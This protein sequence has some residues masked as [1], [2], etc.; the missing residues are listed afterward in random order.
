MQA[1]RVRSQSTAK[2]AQIVGS[3]DVTFAFSAWRA[4]CNRVYIMSNKMS[5]L[6][7]FPASI[8]WMTFAS[9]ASAHPV[10]S[11]TAKPQVSR[12]SEE[13][14]CSGI[15]E[16]ER[17]TSLCLN[18]DEI[19]RV[20]RIPIDGRGGEVLTGARMTFRPVPGRTAES[21]Q[22]V[23][24][25][26][27]ARKSLFESQ[28]QYPGGVY[29]PLAV[30]GVT[31]RVQPVAE[32]WTVEVRPNDSRTSHRISHSLAHGSLAPE[33]ARFESAECRGIEPKVRA[34][35]P[36]LGP[37]TAINDLPQGVRVEFP[38]SVS[39][40]RVLAGMRCHYSF[41]R[42]RGFSEESV[43]CPLYMRGLRLGSSTDGRAID[44]TVGPA[45]MVNEVRKRVR[46][47][48]VFAAIRQ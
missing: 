28:E 15:A 25:C 22:H 27:L 3:E 23:I 14:A 24:D 8:L 30:R 10:S 21:L 2:V 37:V 26:Q 20:E 7:I 32:G 41:A 17:N 11:P 42:A 29:C 34:A 33:L 12:E 38:K 4:R 31:A 43:A 39:V 36:L 35:C 19:L 13:L 16:E 44:I 47:E 46:E 45:A 9:C 5:S 18:T 48:A 1:V 6:R 40:D